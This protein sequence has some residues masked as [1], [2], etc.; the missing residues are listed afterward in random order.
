[1]LGVTHL[2]FA[3]TH[4]EAVQRCNTIFSGGIAAIT[5]LTIIVYVGCLWILGYFFLAGLTFLLEKRLIFRK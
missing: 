1:M 5:F 4:K 3:V 2:H